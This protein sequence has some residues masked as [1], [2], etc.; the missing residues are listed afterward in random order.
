MDPQ[1]G[2]IA[3]DLDPADMSEVISMAV[4]DRSVWLGIRDGGGDGQLVQLDRASGVEVTR[5]A[6]SLPLRMLELDGT[7]WVS[8]Y[9]E[10]RLLGFAA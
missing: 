4:D 9:L 6:V 1:T 3:E 8:D 7:L 5:T 2:K 10:N